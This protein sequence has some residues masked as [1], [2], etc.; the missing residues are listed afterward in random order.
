MPKFKTPAASS[1]LA[2]GQASRSISYP[3]TVLARSAYRDPATQRPLTPY[4]WRVYD[5]IK[6]VGACRA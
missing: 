2:G 3:T 4:Q 6:D 1:A 5:S